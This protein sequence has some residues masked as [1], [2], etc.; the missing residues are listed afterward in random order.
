MCTRLVL[1]FNYRNLPDGTDPLVGVFLK[2]E[3]T[4]KFN[5]IGHTEHQMDKRDPQFER[6]ITINYGGANGHE[7]VVRL[8]VYHVQDNQIKEKG[9]IGTATVTVTQ[10]LD[11]QGK[12][13]DV[14]L[15]NPR[16][17]P[18]ARTLQ[19]LKS[20]VA[21]RNLHALPSGTMKIKCQAKY[22]FFCSI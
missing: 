22:V 20:S 5:F 8:S 10:L 19:D 7:R 18:M 9:L 15:T 12:E 4:P 17:K 3:K 2:E 14:P 11:S 13:I 16:S 1:Q 6:R 21:I